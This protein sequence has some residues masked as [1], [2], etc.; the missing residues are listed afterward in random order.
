MNDIVIL[1]VLILFTNQVKL[2]Q[3]YDLYTENE[4]VG[5]I[6]YINP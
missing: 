2:L 3:T 4:E 1:T 5:N 6:G